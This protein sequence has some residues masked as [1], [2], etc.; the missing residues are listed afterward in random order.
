MSLP[1][2][3]GLEA[4]KQY[5]ED[6]RSAYP[7]LQFTI[8]EIIV[9]GDTTAVWFTFRGTHKGQSTTFPFPPTG[10]EVTMMGC[11]VGH[12]VEGKAVEQWIY[13]DWLGLMQQLGFTLTPLQPPAPQ[14]KE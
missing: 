4:Y 1:D 13:A 7:D 11:T 10:K 9:N 14:E 8:E 12:W 3:E 5:I 2:S 6:T